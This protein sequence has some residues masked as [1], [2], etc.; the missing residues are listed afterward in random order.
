MLLG[1]S[2]FFS[3][4]ETA[5]FS[6]SRLAVSRLEKQVEHQNS[7][8]IIYLLSSPGRLL[9]T[10][11]IGNM[12]VNITASAIATKLAMRFFGPTGISIAIGIMTFL[13]LI[14]GEITP[15]TY[16]VEH[17]SSFA[18]YAAGPLCRISRVLS[19]IISALKYLNDRLVQVGGQTEKPEYSYL[20]A[21]GLRTMI[22]VSEREGILK[23]EEEEMIKG[24]MDFS[25]TLVREVMIPRFDMECLDTGSTREETFALIRE[26]GFSR[27]PVFGENIDDIKGILYVKDL[28]PFIRNRS[29]EFNLMEI[30]HKPFFVPE[31]MKID[32]L[33]KQLQKRK[34]HIA[35]VVDEYGGTEGLVTMEDL[36]E[37]IVGEILDEYDE[38]ERFIEIL[39]EYEYLVLGK[40]DIDE[41]NDELE[42]DLPTEEADSLGGLVMT[43]L[44]RVPEERDQVTVDGVRMVVEEVDGLRINKVR[45]F[46]SLE[47]RGETGI[48]GEGEH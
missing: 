7:K 47:K 27:F 40:I 48:G 5:L 15:K 3:G 12:V 23:E 18:L 35:I 33:L 39:A 38:E 13:L 25:D 17:H 2:A 36:L 8:K 26:T 34:K 45:L 16:A 28:L 43:K 24:I 42:L 32:S 19:P 44:E 29:S 9:I 37:E 20:T 1:L 41:L 6:L 22:K 4:S 14:F 11:L 31:I 30:A 10:I 46:I 21:E